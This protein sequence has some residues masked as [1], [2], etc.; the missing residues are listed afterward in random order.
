M[1]MKKYDESKKENTPKTY[2]GLIRALNIILKC[3]SPY[4]VNGIIDTYN[5][6]YADINTRK[7]YIPITYNQANYMMDNT[8]ELVYICAHNKYYWAMPKGIKSQTELI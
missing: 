3:V 1:W 8:H 6:E 4:T 7:I 2:G 5:D